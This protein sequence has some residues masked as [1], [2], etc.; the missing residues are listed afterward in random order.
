MN[1]WQLNAKLKQEIVNMKS[2]V[3]SLADTL[4]NDGQLYV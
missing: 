1:V 3:Q 4:L 2:N